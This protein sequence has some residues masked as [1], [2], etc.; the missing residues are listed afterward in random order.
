MGT[1]VLTHIN[2]YTFN[3]STYTDVVQQSVK[4]I[5]NDWV[6]TNDGEIEFMRLG[7]FVARKVRDAAGATGVVSWTNFSRE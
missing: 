4:I 5:T 2:V 3:E 7:P 1:I 6:D